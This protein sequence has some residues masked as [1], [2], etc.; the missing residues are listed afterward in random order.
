MFGRPRLGGCG[1]FGDLGGFVGDLGGFGATIGL[2]VATGA[3]TGSKKPLHALLSILCTA[4]H[5]DNTTA[6]NARPQVQLGNTSNAPACPTVRAPPPQRCLTSVR[7][8][9]PTILLRPTADVLP[10]GAKVR[11]QLWLRLR[12]QQP[13]LAAETF[14]GCSEPNTSV[15]ALAEGW[16]FVALVVRQLMQPQTVGRASEASARCC[17]CCC[18]RRRRWR[19]AAPP[20]F[21]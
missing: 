2:G 13:L 21:G 1:F 4:Q 12:H 18:C 5:N 7:L 16:L 15:T 3:T 19:A 10:T 6:I 9:V 17:C 20:V 8:R 14:R 11:P